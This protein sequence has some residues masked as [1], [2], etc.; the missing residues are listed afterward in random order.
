MGRMMGILMI[1]CGVW[2]GLEIYNEGMAGAF[3]GKL[4]WF[5][6]P[7]ESVRKDPVENRSITQR[8]GQRVAAD[9]Y[10]GFERRDN[11][12]EDD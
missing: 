9:I 5:G 10:D 7:I 3:G 2:I 4:A 1:M 12:I 8:V 6:E 11:L